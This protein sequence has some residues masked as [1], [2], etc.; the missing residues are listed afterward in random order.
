[1]AWRVAEPLQPQAQADPGQ[2][3]LARPALLR[4]TTPGA[5]D[6]LARLLAAD[7]A[8]LA[9][10]VA[11]PESA[12]RERAGWLP[13]ADWRAEAGKLK[14]YQPAHDRFYLLAASLAGEGEGWTGEL[15]PD[16]G[17]QVWFVMR[18]LAP[19]RGRRVDPFE[20]KSYAECGWVPKAPGSQEGRWVALDGAPWLTEEERLPLFPWPYGSPDHPQQLYVGGVP[21]ASQAFYQAGEPSVYAVRCLFART[22]IPGGYTVVSE[23]S[24]PFGLATYYDREAPLRTL[25][26]D[27]P[28]QARKVRGKRPG[29]KKGLWQRLGG[30]FRRQSDS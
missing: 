24:A 20:P 8:A 4:F 26:G 9:R 14:L 30:L 16:C 28:R 15:R 27:L 7:P 11:R 29:E 12:R 6:E 19:V 25:P 23:P 3:R 21:V 17:D 1:M 2:E 18:K 10:Y 22:E 5:L 13:Y